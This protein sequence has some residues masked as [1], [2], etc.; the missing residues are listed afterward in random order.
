L[1]GIGAAAADPQSRFR[2]T[3]AGAS[4]D[5]DGEALSSISFGLPHRSLSIVVL[6]CRCRRQRPRDL[7]AVFDGGRRALVDNYWS[8]PIF[9]GDGREAVASALICSI[10]GCQKQKN[11]H[12]RRPD[13]LRPS[14]TEPRWSDRTIFRWRHADRS[15]G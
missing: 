13:R 14:L 5:D 12:E 9:S 10:V 15:M 4:V 1:G 2:M 3:V 8:S 11:R 7:A 6:D